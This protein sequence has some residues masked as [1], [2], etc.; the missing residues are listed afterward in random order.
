MNHGKDNP[1]LI[2]VLVISV[3]VVLLGTYYFYKFRFMN[4]WQK[5]IFPQSTRYNSDNLLEA[6]ICLAA[7]FIQRDQRDYKVKIQYINSYF[8]KYFNENTYN[9]GD[10][11]SWSFKNPIDPKSVVNWVNKH[12]KEE[13]KRMQI[14]YFLVGLSFVDGQMVQG[15]YSILK[16]IT[17]LL[18]LSLKDLDAIV[19]MYNFEEEKKRAQ[20][21]QS[22][23]SSY[24]SSHKKDM[25]LKIL[26]LNLNA[27]S[28]ELKSAY[29][30]LVKI[31]HPD[32]F[33]NESKEQQVLAHEKFIKIQE[34]YEYLD[35]VI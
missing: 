3:P 23:T 2:V 22:T 32:R 15:E 30:K 9:F 27:S 4:K 16:E 24:S 29:R 11:L 20:Y 33:S 25:A 19:N 8:L 26:G 10:S 28:E 14:L 21:S 35:K 12:V 13:T 7:V 5:G 34:A 6:Y 1:I 17:P 18:H 31:H